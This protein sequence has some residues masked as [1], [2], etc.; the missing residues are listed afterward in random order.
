MRP[1]ARAVDPRPDPRPMRGCDV[2]PRAIGGAAIVAVVLWVF[3]AVLGAEQFDGTFGVTGIEV[4]CGSVW[5]LRATDD[6]NAKSCA[7][8]LRDRV[9]LVAVLVGLGLLIVSVAAAWRRS[10]VAMTFACATP[11]VLTIVMIA[12]GRHLIWSVSG[13]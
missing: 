6:L 5:G 4:Q 9:T 12:V 8:D 2:R 13:A 7:D 10:R 11:V 1:G 3:A